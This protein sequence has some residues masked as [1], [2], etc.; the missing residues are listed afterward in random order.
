MQESKKIFERKQEFLKGSKKNA[1][2][3]KNIWAK[4]K[5]FEG[6][7]KKIFEGKQ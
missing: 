2:K 7:Q 1:E 6:K 3:Q 4:A 5:I